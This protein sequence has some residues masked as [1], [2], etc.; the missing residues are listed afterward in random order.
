MTKEML[1][2][3]ERGLAARDASDARDCLIRALVKLDVTK[4]RPLTA[5]DFAEV[6]LDLAKAKRYAHE[7]GVRVRRSMRRQA[8]EQAA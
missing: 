1:S 3:V 4:D 8:K 5:D 6:E 7:A 2:H